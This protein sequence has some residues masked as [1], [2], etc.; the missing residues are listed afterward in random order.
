WLAQ[1]SG[2]DLALRSASERMR[3][4]AA[5]TVERYEEVFDDALTVVRLGASTESLTS[6][7]P[8]DLSFKTDFLVRAL[9]TS[10]HV[11]G[12]FAGY[13]D[14]S[15]VQAANLDSHGASWRKVLDAPDGAAWAIRLVTIAPTGRPVSQ[16]R[17]IDAKGGARGEDRQIETTFDPRKR[18]WYR[19]AAAAEGPITVG[20]YVMV[21]TE[22]I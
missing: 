3:L 14:G 1:K 9:A 6:P 13:P 8:N 16:W 18:P 15:F 7:P 21:V 12:M 17:F 10:P 19:H 22:A 20:P 5:R 11:D 4:L 2:E